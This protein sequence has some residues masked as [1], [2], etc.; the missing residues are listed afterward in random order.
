MTKL[1]TVEGPTT[2]AHALAVE[3]GREGPGWVE[4]STPLPADARVVTTGQSRLADGTSRRPSGPP[5]PSRSQPR[6]PPPAPHPNPHPAPAPDCE[7]ERNSMT[8]SDVCIKR[9]G[10]HLGPG[11]A[12]R[13]ARG[14]WRTASLGVDLFPNVDFPVCTVTTV[15]TGSGVEEME[16]TVTKP[17]EDIINTV[18]G[19][20]ELR[21]TTQEGISVVTDPVLA[22]EERRR[23]RPRGPRQD[24]LDPG[25]PPRR[26]RDAGG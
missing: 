12:P 26:D 7:G 21:S 2:K 11:R 6:Q 17:I 23:W 15:L 24:Q 5:T 25:Q 8:I 9:P 20:D 4:L 3:T 1:F 10:I 14:S 22:L 18:S 19:I 16:T 13:G